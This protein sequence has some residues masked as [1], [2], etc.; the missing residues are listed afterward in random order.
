MG[1]LI[2]FRKLQEK[3]KEDDFIEMWP[4]DWAQEYWPTY[5][6]LQYTM[7]TVRCYKSKLLDELATSGV[8]HEFQI[9]AG[10]DQLECMHEMLM[11]YAQS[12]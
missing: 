12:D 11:F 5:H 6:E 10:L 8:Q 9:R 4:Q 2:E 7:Q 1:Q 3:E